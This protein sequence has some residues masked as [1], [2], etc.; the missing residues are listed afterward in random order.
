MEVGRKQLLENADVERLI[1]VIV[2]RG[3]EYGDM[4]S[5]QDELN[6]HMLELAPASYKPGT[7]VTSNMN[8]SY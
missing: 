3:H 7:K 6:E 2:Q 8:S 4:D 5:I 1:V